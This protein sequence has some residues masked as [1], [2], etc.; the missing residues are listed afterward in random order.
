MPEANNEVAIQH[1]ENNSL[2]VI[3]MDALSRTKWIK[4]LGVM[5]KILHGII[6]NY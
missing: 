5:G 4:V 6:T 3:S 2:N 1:K